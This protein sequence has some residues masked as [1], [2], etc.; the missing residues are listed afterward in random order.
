MAKAEQPVLPQEAMD[1][2]AQ[3]VVRYRFFDYRC[4]DE[5]RFSIAEERLASVVRSFG[6]IPFDGIKQLLDG[7]VTIYGTYQGSKLVTRIKHS[8][9]LELLLRAANHLE[10]AIEAFGLDTDTIANDALWQHLRNAA[11]VE[12][13]DICGGLA[14]PKRHQKENLMV[15]DAIRLRLMLA[16]DNRNG[17]R[18]TQH[19]EENANQATHQ[20][21]ALMELWR[22]SIQAA[23]AIHVRKGRGGARHRPKGEGLMI[24]QLIERYGALRAKYPD[25][26]PQPAGG[27]P[28]YCFVQSAALACGSPPITDKQIE[29]VWGE[30]HKI[31]PD[32]QR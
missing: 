25:S 23:K 18:Q 5:N 32:E 10:K 28:M 31:Q 21:L 24:R 2:I 6:Q 27:G 17:N 12:R 20:L 26:G 3:L 14:D 7:L 15:G 16:T 30:L 8:D 4:T 9:E 29:D 13:L 1:L 22:R 19:S 11:P